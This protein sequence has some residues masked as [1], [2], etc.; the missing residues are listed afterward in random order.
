MYLE[1]EI[2][3]LIVMTEKELIPIYV[4]NFVHYVSMHTTEDYIVSWSEY[5]LDDYP[6]K[7]LTY[8]CPFLVMAGGY[9]DL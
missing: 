8:A 7:K 6:S 1:L 5:N 2:K 4:G 9:G 3:K